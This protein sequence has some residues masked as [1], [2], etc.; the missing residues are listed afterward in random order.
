MK[1]K[2]VLFFIACVTFTASSFAQD[3]K[4]KKVED[5]KETKGGFKK[6]NLFAGGTVALGFGSGTSSIGIG[7]YFGYSINK[8]LDVA[9]SLNYNYTSQRD[10]YSPTKFRQSIIGPGAFVR[11]YPVK[12]LFAHAQF[13][14]NFIQQKIIYGNNFPDE[15]AQ[16]N[17][18]SFLIGP[19]YAS[20]RGEGGSNMFYYISVLFDVAKNIN[21]PYV[22]NQ[23]RV[24]PIFRAGI[25]ISLFQGKANDERYRPRGGRY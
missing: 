22:D 16:V 20:G 25:N 24:N 1:K 8:Y 4:E 14:Q 19:G 6:E 10:Y 15:K 18:P 11:I 3:E 23:G 21:S 17:V 2:I 12:F 13:E 9:L 5:E 7:P